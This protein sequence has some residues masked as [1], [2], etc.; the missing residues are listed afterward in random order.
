MAMYL[1]KSLFVM[2]VPTELMNNSGLEAAA[3]VNK[4]WKNWILFVLWHFIKFSKKRKC[5]YLPWMLHL[6][7]LHSNGN[8]VLNENKAHTYSVCCHKKNACQLLTATNWLNG[9]HKIIITNNRQKPK[10]V[11]GE[12]NVNDYPTL[13]SLITSES[14]WWKL[15]YGGICTVF[16][17]INN[18]RAIQGALCSC[19]RYNGFG[20]IYCKNATR[21][22]NITFWWKKIYNMR[23]I[24]WNKKSS[25]TC[26]FPS[27]IF[28]ENI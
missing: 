23:W 9:R 24:E 20:L 2:N 27:V 18:C 19:T 11:A 4:G 14:V 10:T 1:P 22:I 25:D 17:V 6:Q 16:L 21:S 26:L 7:H 12:C 5:E 8:L 28:A 3:I 15:Q 13:L